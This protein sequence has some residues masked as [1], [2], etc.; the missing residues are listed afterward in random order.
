MLNRFSIRARLVAITILFLVPIALLVYL[1]VDQSRKDITFADKEVAGVAYLRGTWP[2]LHALAAA[3]SDPS[4]QPS[5]KLGSAPKLELAAQ[6]YD[7]D[8]GSEQASAELG[9]ALAAIGWPNQTIAGEK[10]DA[11]VTAA[12]ALINRSA[13]RR[14]SF[15]IP[16]STATT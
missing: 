15:S 2:V 14:T 1:F 13:M 4:T 6:T 7:A 16:I 5:A 3:A 12:R 9:K 11:A 10:A 8:M